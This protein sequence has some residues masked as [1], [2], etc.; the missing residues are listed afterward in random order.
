[1]EKL[2]A[3]RKSGSGTH[4]R[5]ST[6]SRCM[7]A[8]CPAGPPKL[9]KPS[10]SQKRNA[11]PKLTPAGSDAGRVIGG[12]VNGGPG[13][14]T[15]GPALAIVCFL[16]GSGPATAWQKY[17]QQL[18]PRVESCRVRAVLGRHPLV[19]GHA[20]TVD[21]V[22]ASGLPDCDVEALAPR[23]EPDRVWVNADRHT[24]DLLVAG[25]IDHDETAGVARD[26]STFRSRIEVQPVWTR[27]GDRD[28]RAR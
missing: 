23:V 28:L 8:I 3:R 20:L 15:A 17:V 10:F 13:S 19:D 6:S 26:E 27:R 5:W 14:G 18:P 24:G 22:D 21:H 12:A 9:I 1:M 4:R 16:V 7:M 25:E 11:S 2:R